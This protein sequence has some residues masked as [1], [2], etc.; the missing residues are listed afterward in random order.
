MLSSH[1]GSVLCEWGAVALEILSWDW[2]SHHQQDCLLGSLEL[3]LPHCAW[4]PEETALNIAFLLLHAG[5]SAD[6]IRTRL[7]GQ[8]EWN[9]HSGA[10]RHLR[11]TQ[12]WMKLIFLS[13]F[14]TLKSPSLGTRV[15]GSQVFTNLPAALRWIIHPRVQFPISWLRETGLAPEHLFQTEA[16][17]HSVAKWLRDGCCW[18]SWVCLSWAGGRNCLVMFMVLGS[19]LGVVDHLAHS[20]CDTEDLRGLVHW[21]LPSFGFCGMRSG[22]YKSEVTSGEA[23]RFLSRMQIKLTNHLS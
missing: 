1:P 13:S 6:K 9:F 16:Q 12:Q 14:P 5:R 11:A 2:V 15:P 7:E 21:N 4:N 10:C 23:C 3:R 22:S 18:G 17:C 8:R 20:C 19:G